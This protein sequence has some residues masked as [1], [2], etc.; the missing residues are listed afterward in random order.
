MWGI[1]EFYYVLFLSKTGAITEP[2][3]R[4]FFLL[5][6]ISSLNKTEVDFQDLQGFEEQNA[7]LSF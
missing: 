6:M 1:V 7:C 4:I 5:I 3:I 2:V